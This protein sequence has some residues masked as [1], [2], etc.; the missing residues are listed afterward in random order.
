MKTLKTFSKIGVISVMALSLLAAC[1]KKDGGGGAAAN[2]CDGRT[3]GTLGTN[4]QMC[5]NGQPQPGGTGNLLNNV[6]FQTNHMQGVLNLIG[7]G[8]NM[9]WADP[10]VYAYY[11]GPVTFSGS[12]TVLDNAYCGA[13]INTPLAVTG[14][15]NFVM[16]MLS[17][18][19]LLAGQV[20]LMGSFLNSIVYNPSGL[21]RDAQG[22][23]IEL[24]AQLIVNGQPCG[25]ISTY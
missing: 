20:Q 17:S 3:N 1:G 9:N 22:N 4:G 2:P 5:I 7:T 12:L 15:A 23:R 8:T 14:T 11:N 10:A 24:N 25:G 19:N 6:Q 21:Y 18:V 16:G 13:P